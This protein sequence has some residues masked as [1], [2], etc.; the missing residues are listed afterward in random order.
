MQWNTA[1]WKLKGN[2]IIKN[3]SSCKTEFAQSK[4]NHTC[5]VCNPHSL[6]F[7]SEISH[8]ATSLIHVAKYDFN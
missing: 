2:E 1:V 5:P 4:F 8:D 6:I 7:W 3:I